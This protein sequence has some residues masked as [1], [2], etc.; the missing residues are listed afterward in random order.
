[1][2]KVK[3]EEDPAPFGFSHTRLGMERSLEKQK[4]TIAAVSRGP[5]QEVEP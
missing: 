2:N 5:S 1:M 3:Q 4:Y